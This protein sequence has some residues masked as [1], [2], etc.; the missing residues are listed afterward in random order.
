[1]I[2][3]VKV[4]LGRDIVLGDGIVN[5]KRMRFRHKLGVGNEVFGGRKG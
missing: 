1:M 4:G 3:V 2:G 5:M